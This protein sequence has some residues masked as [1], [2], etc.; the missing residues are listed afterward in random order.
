MKQSIIPVWGKAFLLALPFMVSCQKDA[1]QD[2]TAGTAEN[3]TVAEGSFIVDYTAGAESRAEA[4][5]RIQSLDYLVYENSGANGAYVLKKHR[6][7]PDIN[8]E[9]VWPLTRNTMTWAQREA[10][11][12]TLNTSCDYKVVFVANAD[13]KIWDEEVLKNVGTE[14]TFEEARLFLPSTKTFDDTNMYYMWTGELSGAS[15]SKN[16]PA[17]MQILLERMINRVEVKLDETVAA[18]IAEKGVDTY[19]EE[20]LGAYFDA[21]YV[22]E[23]STGTLD[24]IVFEYI[25][26]LNSKLSVKGFTDWENSYVSTKKFKNEIL[27]SS[28]NKKKVVKEIIKCRVDDSS[29]KY[30]SCVKHQ[31]ISE[32]K[33]YFTTCCDWSAISHAEIHYSSTAYPQAIG[34]DKLTKAES[35]TE[36]IILAQKTEGNSLLFYAFGNNESGEDKVIN[37]I[38]SVSFIGNDDNEL[39]NAPVNTVPVNS[40]TG[41]N[42]SLVLS[43]NPISSISVMTVNTDNPESYFSFERANFNLQSVIGW[44]WETDFKY[45]LIIGG[46]HQDDMKSWVNEGIKN[47]TGNQEE[48][49]NDMTLQLNIPK[50]EIVNP[51]TSKENK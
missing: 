16:N 47:F 5:V 40:L 34:F 25:D 7:I 24:K 3:G 8:T 38:A 11:K 32:E 26:D 10:L 31:F 14:N 13:D 4:S 29:S 35:G 19:V 12:D 22:K 23:D 50:V 30:E 21:N 9:T 33:T 44:N 43:Y 51:W 48:N 2:F 42:R 17:S 20:Q 1:E 45:D 6:S 15:Y 49:Y 28:D 18:G 36:G 41:G 37:R 46:W 27:G 39:F